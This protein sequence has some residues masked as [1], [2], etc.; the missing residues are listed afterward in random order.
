M[1]TKSFPLNSG[2][3]RLTFN[4]LFAAAFFF[5]VVMMN[6]APDVPEISITE[7]KLELESPKPPL[8]I[9]V[10]GPESWARMHIAGAMHIPKDELESRPKALPLD[11]AQRIV[12]YCGDGSTLGPRGVAKLQDMGYTNVVNMSRGMEGWRD[13][14]L[15]TEKGA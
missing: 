4:I 5:G 6:R 11:K 2:L 7:A 10:R 13:A 8:L 14:G 15:K 3:A 1:N 9:D 12:V